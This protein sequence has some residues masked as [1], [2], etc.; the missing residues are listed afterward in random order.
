MAG[1]THKPLNTRDAKAQLREVASH[2]GASHWIRTHPYEAVSLGV[3]TGMLLGSRHRPPL[4]L[5]A[6]A[7]RLIRILL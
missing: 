2:T 3:A 6:F 4:A 1:K 7:Q 5:L